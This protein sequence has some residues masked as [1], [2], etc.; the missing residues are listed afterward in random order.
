VTNFGLIII[1]D[2]I[3]SGKLQD[4]H[5]AKLV[6]PLGARSLHQPRK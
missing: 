4:K 5:F 1:S 2:E 6:E 3:L